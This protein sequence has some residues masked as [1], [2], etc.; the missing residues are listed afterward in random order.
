M[1]QKFNR[2]RSLGLAAI[3]SLSV[4]A[5]ALLV[6]GQAQAA[7]LDRVL[8][9][10]DE[11]SQSTPTTGTVCARPTS[12][13]TEDH[14][15][16][17]FPAGF[18][19]STTAGNWTTNTTNTAW[20]SGANAWTGIGS[21]S[22]ASQAV[23]F[24]SADLTPGT[25]YCFNWDNSAALSQ[26]GS[27]G[28]N[29]G[30]FVTTRNTGVDIDTGAFST[31]TI[32]NDTITVTATVAQT[33]SFALSGTTDP[34]GTLPTG[35]VTTSGTPRTVTVN[36]NAANGWLVWGKDSQTGLHST[37]N[38]HTIA[39][40]TPGVASTLSAGTE[41]YNT[42]IANSQTGG[43][44]TITVTAAYADGGLGTG[45]GLSTT[46]RTLATS[47][48]TANG[49]VLTFKNNVAISTTTQ[50]ATDYQDIITLTGAGLF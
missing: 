46:L 21:P 38:G 44:G 9:R 48:G 24:T 47:N 2:V 42:G 27:P 34:L 32:V 4:A 16:V 33:F 12:T 14:V 28:T 5:P 19:V 25:L 41:G 11:M 20:P 10:F 6:A 43:T 7:G 31:A 30:G 26:P 23:T 36:T 13:T 18:T 29:E 37:L 49:A 17:D 40:V 3:L 39:S 22:I 50:A 15:R 35:S 8:V 45:A 1:K